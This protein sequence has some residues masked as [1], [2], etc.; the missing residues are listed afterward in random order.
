[1]FRGG[2]I[3][4]IERR[5][6]SPL[7]ET[8][9]LANRFG[10]RNFAG[11]GAGARNSG[12]NAPMSRGSFL[13]TAGVAAAGIAASGVLGSAA[14]KAQIPPPTPNPDGLVITKPGGQPAESGDPEIWVHGTQSNPEDPENVQWAVDNVLAGGNVKLLGTFHFSDAD[15]NDRLIYDSN[16]IHVHQPFAPWYGPYFGLPL[17]YIPGNATTYCEY[18]GWAISP[19]LADEQGNPIYLFL[20]DPSMP[21]IP[22]KVY[23]ANDKRVFITQSVKLIGE[24]ASIIGGR[25]TLTLGTYPVEPIYDFFFTSILN[26]PWDSVLF[27]NPG[28]RL[29]VTIE[30]I[31][32]S[33]SLSGTILDTSSTSFT[34]KGN[35]FGDMRANSLMNYT[36]IPF[37][38]FVEYH[39]PQAYH[40]IITASGTS[41]IPDLAKDLITGPVV[42]SDNVFEGNSR[43]VPV[44]TGSCNKDTHFEQSVVTD[45]GSMATT[46]YC[47]PY[48][49]NAQ[50]RSFEIDGKPEILGWAG[51]TACMRA[52]LTNADILVTRNEV[53][54]IQSLGFSCENNYGTTYI[55]DNYIEISNEPQGGDPMPNAL[56]LVDTHWVGE[57]Y[58]SETTVT[59]NRIKDYYP[60]TDGSILVMNIDGAVVSKNEIEMF[61]PGED[62]EGMIFIGMKNSFVGQNKMIGSADKDFLIIADDWSFLP[63]ILPSFGNEFTGNNLAK[64]SGMQ[65]YYL[66]RLTYS[67]RVHGYTGGNDLVIDNNPIGPYAAMPNYLTGVTPMSGAGGAGNSVKEAV[68][69]RSEAAA[70]WRDTLKM[71]KNQFGN[72]KP[73]QR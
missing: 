46:P 53:Y 22:V 60:F 63:D 21:K 67:N 66:S 45:I 68:H 38:T 7:G 47:V 19:H 39:H 70:R 26:F 42:I 30:G 17:Y 5:M 4:T 57:P 14:A 43:E 56:W 16:G 49:A 72:F 71:L 73:P 23:G 6:R 32:F 54:G 58:I 31:N 9:A 37:S 51:A 61:G 25:Y 64:T 29:D 18:N 12:L 10:K 1:M 50:L 28:K 40:M 69:Q 48:G 34:V 36:F 8:M 24:N 20:L 15:G 65:T 3:I 55:T 13:R 27:G 62:K 35:H 44:T 52:M 59:G 33:K 11:I 2:G 41:T